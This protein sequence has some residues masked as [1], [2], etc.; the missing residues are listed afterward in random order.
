LAI[1][2]HWGWHLAEAEKY[3]ILSIQYNYKELN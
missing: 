1:I 3:V 2:Q